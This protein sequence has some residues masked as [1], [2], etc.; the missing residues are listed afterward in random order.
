MLF[1]SHFKEE[2]IRS[3]GVTNDF[4]NVQKSDQIFRDCLQTSCAISVL[5]NLSAVFDTI[6]H[7]IILGRLEVEVQLQG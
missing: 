6:D 7:A 5:L 2:G 1:V 3:A 4:G